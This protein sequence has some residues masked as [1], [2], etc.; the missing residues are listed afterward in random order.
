M[1]VI[2]P[3]QKFLIIG[4]LI[5]LQLNLLLPIVYI[6]YFYCQVIDKKIYLVYN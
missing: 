4:Q 1:E 3:K 2:W 6:L 5:E